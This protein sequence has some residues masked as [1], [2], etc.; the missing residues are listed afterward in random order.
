MRQ[1][2]LR[3]HSLF[4]SRS[5]G[6]VQQTGVPGPRMDV[7]NEL[8]TMREGHLVRLIQ[9]AETLDGL[10]RVVKKNSKKLTHLHVAVAAVK[11][12]RLTMWVR[13]PSPSR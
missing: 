8:S 5:M 11:L 9:H 13:R 2:L 7:A 12:E 1:D 4:F 10:E 6:S 3:L